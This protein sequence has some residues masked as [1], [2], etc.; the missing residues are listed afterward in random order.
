MNNYQ[1]MNLKKLTYQRSDYNLYIAFIEIKK[2]LHD[3]QIQK[4]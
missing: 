2:N 4:Y 3:I 1:K